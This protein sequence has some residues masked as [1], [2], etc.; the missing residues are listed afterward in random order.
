MRIKV[1]ISGSD[2]GRWPRPD[3][4]FTLPEVLIAMTVF[5]LVIIGVVA[6]NLFGLKMFQVT[7]TK[8]NVTTWSRETS[9][10][11]TAEVHACNSVWVGNVATNGVFAT[12]LDGEKQQGTGLLIYPTTNTTNFIIYFVNPADQTFRRTTGQPGTAEILA[13]SVTNTQVFAAEDFSGNVLTNNDNN[14][15]IHLTLEFYQP[16]R[17]LL[18][19]DYYKMETSM[20]RRALQ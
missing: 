18:G 19:A 16:A 20:T 14:R 15:V 1:P 17:F 8:L 6:A 3:E 7:Q 9:D 10:K 11:I 13:D 12:L 4:G 2:H 5:L